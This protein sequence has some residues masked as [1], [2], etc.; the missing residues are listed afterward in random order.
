M[1]GQVGAP[2]RVVP[3]DEEFERSIARTVGIHPLLAG[4]LRNRGLT[5]TEQIS[6]FIQPSPDALLS[7]ENLPDIGPATERI[8]VAIHSREPVLVHGDYDVDGIC[9]TA[10]LVR[11]LRK[12]DVPVQPHIPH[13]INDQYGLD[14][15]A[16]VRAAQ[17]G[18]KLIIAVDC[19][20]RATEP[21]AAA[22]QA[23]ADVIV[24]DHHEP[25]PQLPSGAWIIDPKRG[26][27]QYPERELAAV[28]LAFK[29]A[30]AVCERLSLSQQSLQQAFLD[31][32]ALGTIADM[33]PLV[34]ENRTMARLGLQLLPRTRKAGLR[35]LLQVCQLD[36]TV[37]ASD[38]AFRL[39]PRLNAAGRMA[40]ATEALEL[41]LTDD[42]QA[43]QKGALR[44]DSINRDRRAQQE[45]V[46]SEA[47]R[48]VEGQIDLEDERIIVLSS[49]R[50]HLGV[51]GIVA[52]KLLDKYDRPA[53]LLVEEDGR[54]RGS[55][56]S[57]E[58]LDMAATLQEC[59][60]LLLRH[61]GHATAAG[62][63]LETANVQAFRER[64]NALAAAS[65]SL[66]ELAPA[67]EADAE[68]DLFEVD[69]EL[70]KDLLLLEP[71][72][73]GNPE[74]LFVARAVE[75]I[76]CQLV[77]SSAQHLKLSVAH[78]QPSAECI[79]FGMSEEAQ[80]IRRGSRVD[81][82]FTPEINEYDGRCSIQLRLQAIR[83]ATSR[84]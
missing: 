52:S 33:A 40:D 51:V 73:R 84:S 79:G 49:P 57:I 63:T 72:G 61:G 50:W 28:G 65:I 68:V 3:R 18:I 38:V 66:E 53:I 37:T 46:Y 25:G 55:A 77:G 20:V 80:W 14:G 59:S 19:G 8:A 4:A 82:C 69:A 39:A 83:P 44:L 76:N 32:V 11:F 62:L 9:S 7:P 42:E 17:S 13:R 1:A 21:I 43:A 45:H 54:A 67:L 60:D 30:T 29:L 31:L 41:L 27:N 10:L 6:D 48:E 71:C 24:V 5:T 78:E 47:L 36:A 35:A 23:G 15:P 64:I 22:R 2:W 70:V 34:G 74:P 81:I 56:R 12:L 58:G 26:D 16:L 75:I